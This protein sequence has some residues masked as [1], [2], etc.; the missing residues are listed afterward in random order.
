[1]SSRSRW[2]LGFVISF[3]V[4][5]LTVQRGVAWQ[6]SGHFLWRILEG[7]WTGREGL[8]LAHVGWVALG[9][10][11]AWVDVGPFPLRIHLLSAVG[12][13]AA[14]ANLGWLL[15]DELGLDRRAVVATQVTLGG[16]HAAWWLATVAEVYTWN[17]ALMTLELILLARLLKNP[18]PGR[19]A[20]LFGV[21]GLNLTVHN[22]SLLSTA[23]YGVVLLGLL[24]RRR[25]G[26]GALGL[27]GGAWLLGAAPLLVFS[28][29]LAASEGPWA[30]LR[31]TLVGDFGAQV[32]AVTPG[33][34]FVVNLALG[35]LSFASLLLPLAVL[36]LGRRDALAGLRPALLGLLLVHG[37][38]V[39]RYPVPD[40]FTFLLPTLVVLSVAAGVGLHRVFV[41]R[42]RSL[43]FGAATVSAL[44]SPIACLLLPTLLG[45]AGL[46]GRLSRPAWSDVRDEGR[47][48]LQPWK[49]DE[50][51][52]A[53]F[54][55]DALAALEA[56]A[57]NAV[58]LLVGTA[59]ETV[60]VAQRI[61]GLAP[62]VT[63]QYYDD[64][65]PPFGDDPDAFE[66]ALAGRPL[67]VRTLA[68]GYT[69]PA[70]LDHYTFAPVPGAPLYRA[71]A[72]APLAERR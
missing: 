55:H 19:A 13:A 18:A 58:L 34:Y 50:D 72:R 27:A 23:V 70:L 49:H 44:G 35:S 45:A 41:E 9:R 11:A 30:A 40:Q 25:L 22:L 26:W 32:A 31:S 66:R 56:E 71:D 63:V 15:R 39:V 64:P 29:R 46:D 57:P 43:A 1:M 17:A 51:S 33:G 65:L 53:R 4:Y 7:D 48:W 36:G 67:Y 14:V 3:A 20:A 10:V 21:V 6:D 28:L 54:A 60:L 68:A 47:Y 8:A 2:L 24:W 52:A 61:H 38:F 5:A 37:V 62:E 12:M 42:G 59:Q 16:A 69:D